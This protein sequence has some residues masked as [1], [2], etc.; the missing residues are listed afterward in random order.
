[1][2]AEPL[3]H[4]YKV[5]DVIQ[6]LQMLDPEAQVITVLWSK[7]WLNELIAQRNERVSNEKPLPLITTDEWEEL[8][9]AI[10]NRKWF[11]FDVD[12]ISFEIAT[13]FER[14][15]YY[16]AEWEKLVANYYEHEWSEIVTEETR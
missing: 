16:E 8:V 11:K 7:E 14:S 5:A 15:I 2:S 6:H 12:N 10:T 9:Q 1:M 3:P 4:A 13:E